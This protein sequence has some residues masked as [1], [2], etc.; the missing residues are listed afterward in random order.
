M[1]EKLEK[2]PYE[3]KHL[4][5]DCEYLLLKKPEC[6]IA[7]VALQRVS[8]KSVSVH[9]HVINW[10]HTGL[11]VM[12]RDWQKIKNHQ[13]KLGIKLLIAANED[14]HDE[15]WPRFIELFGFKNPILVSYA[16]QEI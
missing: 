14:I 6:D 7:Y 16:T 8:G 3:M 13:Q 12:L 15:K 11:K 10:S 4:P 5:E 1:I 2:R 9:L